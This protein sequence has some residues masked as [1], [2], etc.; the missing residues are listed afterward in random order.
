MHGK[1]VRARVVST[2]T[3]SLHGVKAG[4]VDTRGCTP[5]VALCGPVRVKARLLA[6]PLTSMVRRHVRVLCPGTYAAL[7]I[8]LGMRTD[9]RACSLP[10]TAMTTL[11]N[12]KHGLPTACVRNSDGINTPICSTLPS[13][14][15]WDCARGFSCIRGGGSWGWQ[16]DK[17]VTYVDVKR[18]LFD[19]LQDMW[20][21]G[22]SDYEG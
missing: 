8:S 9:A 5:E 4:R 7:R 14:L 11:S 15:C 3:P 17:I 2:A 6:Q 19:C 20:D 22:A 1:L 16:N 12:V 21:E 10:N 18:Y 13:P